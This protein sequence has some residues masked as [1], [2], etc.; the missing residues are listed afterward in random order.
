[1]PATNATEI[2]WRAETGWPLDK[3]PY[4][5]SGVWNDDDGRSDEDGYRRDC[6]G[7]ASLA[8]GITAPGPSTVGLVDHMHRIT[9]A[10][11]RPGDF[12][13][14]GGPGTAG[15]AG[16]VGVVTHVDR[17]AGTY[18]ILHQAGGLG[19]DRWGGRIGVTP[20]SGM[21]PYR[22]NY[23]TSGGIVM[24]CKHGDKGPVVEALQRLILA[25]GGALPQWGVDGDY[26]DET[27]A[28]LNAVLGGTG[29]EYGPAQY[30]LLHVRLAKRYAAAPTLV[31][32]THKITASSGNPTT[33]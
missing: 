14:L 2:V 16:H 24:F 18:K 31:P 3:V 26:G 6:S 4:S 21:V 10:E 13:M 20:R 23:I 17:A 29:R 1:M 12:I 5:Q 25:A 11:L 28:G 7:F 8:L 30:A 9:W 27:A 15:N 32:H 19:P 33:S 22:S